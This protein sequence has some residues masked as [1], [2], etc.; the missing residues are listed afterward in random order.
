VLSWASGLAGVHVTCPMSTLNSRMETM[1][2]LLIARVLC[3]QWTNP[4]HVV[5]CATSVKV[6]KGS[7]LFTRH[8]SLNR[9]NE[10]TPPA[11]RF[12]LAQAIVHNV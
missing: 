5:P 3:M 12:F 11:A 9:S 8:E 7:Q 4:S 1:C 10:V 6:N 2:S